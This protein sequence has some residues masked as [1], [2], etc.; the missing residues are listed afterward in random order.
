MMQ[1]AGVVDQHHYTVYMEL[2]YEAAMSLPTT[3]T[4]IELTN[5]ITH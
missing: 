1:A 3:L 2:N 5:N 4:S